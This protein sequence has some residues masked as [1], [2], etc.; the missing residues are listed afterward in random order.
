MIIIAGPSASGKT[1]LANY[2][3]EIGFGK[4]LITDTTRMQREHETDGVDYNFVSEE[5]FAKLLAAGEYIE[6][7]AYER[8]EEDGVRRIVRYGSRR[9]SYHSDTIAVLT[10]SGV[11][12]VRKAKLDATVLFLEIPK[13][14]RIT[15]GMKRG[16]REEEVL[17]RAE[18]DEQDFDGFAKEANII[19]NNAGY[20]R[21]VEE[22]ANYLM[23]Y[24]RV[25]KAQNRNG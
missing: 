2:L 9:T 20:E 21:S 1:T 23:A 6:T 10:P 17:R 14:D 19:V 3:E 16:D 24:M 13:E 12:A 15:M 18:T 5:E 4:R 11:R 7:A 25:K 8:I 22:I